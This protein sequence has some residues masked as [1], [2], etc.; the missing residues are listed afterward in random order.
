MFIRNNKVFCICI[1]ICIYYKYLALLLHCFCSHCFNSLMYHFSWA[2]IVHQDDIYCVDDILTAFSYYYNP[3]TF[4]R[5]LCPISFQMH[6]KPAITS[7]LHLQSVVIAHWVCLLGGFPNKQTTWTVS[8]LWLQSSNIVS[9]IPRLLFQWDS[10]CSVDSTYMHIVCL[11]S[12]GIL[13]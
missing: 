13:G 3:W 11:S 8:N 6:K 9:C 7:K 10:K 1:C 5:K 4:Q 12:T 2:A